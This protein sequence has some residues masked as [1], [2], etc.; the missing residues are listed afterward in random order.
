[1]IRVLLVE[2]ELLVRRKVAS[3]LA[4]AVGRLSVVGSC[5]SAQEALDLL[6][7]GL[8]M[9]VALVGLRL[10]DKPGAELIRTIRRMR[11]LASPIALSRAEDAGTIFEALRAGAR[12]YLLMDTPPE[13]LIAGIEEV[14][15]GGAPMSPA[16]ARR[17][18]ESFSGTASPL[19]PPGDDGLT[20]REKDVLDRLTQGFTYQGIGHALGVGLSTVQGHIKSIYR[21]LDVRSKAEATAVALKR[22]LVIR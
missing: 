12:G 2:D 15:A 9:E 18:V 21:K 3:A 4:G 11:P 13:R 17:V 16:V 6:T 22:G 10:P 1:M 8:D 19:P 7:G 14:V 5:G 20:P